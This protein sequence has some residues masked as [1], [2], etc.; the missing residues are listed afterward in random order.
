MVASVAPHPRVHTVSV[1]IPVYQGE[2]TLGPII[3]ELLALATDSV[4]PA[5]N[6]YRVAE[7]V[8]V[9]DNGPD[10]SDVVIRGLEHDHEFVHAVWLSRN[11]GQH[12][13]TLAGIATSFGDWVVTLDEDGQ[14]DPRDISVLLD[15]ALQGRAQVVYAKPTNEAPHGWLRN[16]ASR[17]SKRLANRLLVAPN[18]ADYNSYRLIVGSVARG[19]AAY[20]GSGVYL[21]VALGWVA[22]RYATA[23]TMLRGEVRSSGYN[24]RRLVG[25]FGRLVL[26]SGTR[27][28]RVVSYIGVA[29]TVVGVALA[30]W[31]IVVRLTAHFD[32][33]GWASTV[34]ILLLTSGATL[35]SLGIIAEY[36]GVSVNMAMGKPAY[37]I[38]SDPN[39]GPLGA[40][41]PTAK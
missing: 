1:V 15:A 19:V 21:D 7:V 37:L 35:F 34:V 13:A 9:Y 4:S 33:A 10:L 28:L 25:H 40:R 41:Q 14:H 6:S 3:D 22:G 11:F 8:L 5:G 38:T 23:P 18:A 2:S 31:V 16:V 26:T 29:F 32:A 24:L 20:A 12:A 30:I 17:G 39:D 27:G 36:V